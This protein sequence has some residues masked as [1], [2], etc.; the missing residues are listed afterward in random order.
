MNVV[1]V[2]YDKV[3]THEPPLGDTI[4]LLIMHLTVY[5]ITHQQSPHV[6]GD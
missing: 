2:V 4:K 6:G 1:Y 3:L 5:H